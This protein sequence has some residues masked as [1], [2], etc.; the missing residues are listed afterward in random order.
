MQKKTEKNQENLSTLSQ[1]NTTVSVKTQS[2][3]DRESCSSCCSVPIHGGIGMFL[4]TWLGVKYVDVYTY[5]LIYLYTYILYG[6][7]RFAIF[8]G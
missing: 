2:F 7:L 4:A 8:I 1:T 6:C 3:S 5:I